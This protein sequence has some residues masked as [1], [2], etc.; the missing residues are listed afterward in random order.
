MGSDSL[1]GAWGFTMYDQFWLPISVL[2]GMTA[3]MLVLLLILLK[4]RDPV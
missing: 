2:L 3:L 1:K 4:G